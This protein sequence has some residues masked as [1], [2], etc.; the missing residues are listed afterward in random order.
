MANEILNTPRE[1]THQRIADMLEHIANNMSDSHNAV[2]INYDNSQSDIEADEVQ[3][4]IDELANQ[5]ADK[6]DT[7]SKSSI[8]TSLN[9]K[10]DKE[11]GKEL[12]DNL[13]LAAQFD[14][15]LLY[16]TSVTQYTYIKCFGDP[17]Y[18][19]EYLT[20]GENYL[21]VLTGT[22]WGYGG[23]DI[24]IDL[25]VLPQIT[26]NLNN[27]R[28]SNVKFHQGWNDICSNIISE[29]VIGDPRMIDGIYYI[30]SGSEVHIFSV[31][32]S[33]ST[34]AQIFNSDTK[35]FNSDTTF[36]LTT[37]LSGMYREYSGEKIVSIYSKANQTVD[38]IVFIPTT[39]YWAKIEV[40]HQ[41][42]DGNGGH[43]EYFSTINATKDDIKGAQELSG[44]IITIEDASATNL[45][46]CV[47]DL[48]PI[49]DL[50]GYDKPWI[51]GAGKNKLPLDLVWIKANNTTGTWSGNTYS[52]YGVTLNVLTDSAGN[53]TGI[54]TDGMSNNLIVFRLCP[55]TTF[56]GYMALTGCPVNGSGNTW[57]I[58]MF[59]DTDSMY[60]AGDYG[61]GYTYN[62]IGKEYHAEIV[63][64]NNQDVSNK[65][66][67]PM[68]TD[69]TETD[70]TFE[71][72]T[73]ICPISGY[74]EIELTDCGKNL[75]GFEHNV[76]DMTSVYRQNPAQ[77]LE[78][79]SQSNPNS[80]KCNYTSGSWGIGFVQINGIDG[81]K[82]Y[83]LNYI[84]TENTTSYK[85]EMSISSEFSDREKLVIMISGGNRDTAV[86]SSQYFILSNIQLELGTEP[87]SY[88]PYQGKT[89]KVQVGQKNLFD[90]DLLLNTSGWVKSG[91]VYSG[92]TRNVVDIYKS[93][94]GGF[95]SIRFKNNTQYTMSFK[96][97]SDNGSSIGFAF[98][99]TDGSR[100][101]Q[102]PSANNQTVKFSSTSDA[103]KT[104]DYISATYNGDCN[105]ELSEIQLEEGTQV[106]DYAT[107]DP[108]LPDA[109][110]GAEI[111]WVKG[112]MKVTHGEVDLGELTP[113]LLSG[114]RWN[115]GAISDCATVAN[116][117]AIGAI[118]EQYQVYSADSLY[119]NND[120]IGFGF[121]VDKNLLVR[122]GSSTISPTGKI[123]YP[124]A[125]PYEIPLTPQQIK[126]LKGYNT[127]YS[128]A[129][130]ITLKYQPDNVTGDTLQAVESEYDPKIAE[131]DSRLEG[132][133]GKNLLKLTVDEIKVANT[134]GVW[135]GNSYISSGCTF[136]ILTDDG[137]TVNGIK[138]NGTS[139]VI[140][141][142]W[143]ASN[144]TIYGQHILSGCPNGGG[145]NSY[146]L[147]T[148]SPTIIDIGESVLI[149]Y[150]TTYNCLICIRPNYTAKNLIFRPMIRKATIQDGT[151]EPWIPSNAELIQTLTALSRT[152]SDITNRL[153]NL[154]KAVAEQCLEK[155]GYK[156]GD[157]FTGPI[158]NYT[159]HLANPN[160]FKGPS[161]PYCL[162]TN[163]LS[164][165]V[166]THKTSQWH[167]GDA[168]SVG[169][170]G[171][172]LHAYLKGTVMDNIKADF[173]AL[174][175]GSTGLEH[176]L[177]H[178]KLFTTAL[179][180]WA[181]QSNQYISALTC[182]QIDGG[183]QWTANG[184]QEGEASKSLELFRKYKW[185]E[186][187]GSE[188]PW[189]RNISNYNGGLSACYAFDLGYL[190]GYYSVTDSFFVVGLIN[191]Y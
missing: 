154:S 131:Y 36:L 81:T 183:S 70:A 85:P 129:D 138:V 69:S 171:S 123:I 17:F 79:S 7:Y 21:D 24:F 117:V 160:T 84:V 29:G 49:Q 47:V 126:L 180:N 2:N 35:I 163:H 188:Y 22:I 9:K 34:V 89:Y 127:I 1:S 18:I 48:E 102:Y 116:N 11:D 155:Y 41:P 101:V 134:S 189:L 139:S 71:P 136:E 14:E 43:I 87:T 52:I 187:F 177:P 121:N 63:I 149:N 60:L 38:S 168:S 114:N 145:S 169:Y 179:A 118:S 105:V 40:I 113:T 55:P 58:Q 86:S 110:Y 178:S 50:H 128:N 76:I 5:K 53:V 16:D 73:N 61:N 37:L 119:I 44:E 135:D 172:V 4:A 190:G 75:F 92:Y 95:P 181:W 30:I 103:N 31:E 112:A 13:G 104:I 156:I 57:Q 174:F 12:F 133:A 141:Y 165:V 140:I 99:Y 170:N 164:I 97:K 147:Y 146:F 82:D 111:D 157:Y 109:I 78:I 173:K 27:L 51:G 56:N 186:I 106:T 150:T 143:L 45:Q 176:L 98:Y 91:D 19:A 144:L 25:E 46:E 137:V 148:E 83:S 152:R 28:V 94:N 93:E 15:N 184:F 96:I 132:N 162:T 42:N 182:T 23:G 39:Q 26:T 65:V 167:S 77:R 72:Y 142:F 158:A 10:V 6:D 80:I 90:S 59:N 166:D 120:L 88:E 107:Y 20:K 125:Q 151:F 3:G 108:S 62:Y 74:T 175:G 32:N 64:R 122:N 100:T 68:I 67:Y 124:I 66:F 54:K 153:G 130:N 115:F 33:G 191:F 161:T 185:T 8:D 159:Y